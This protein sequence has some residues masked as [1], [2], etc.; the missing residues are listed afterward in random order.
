VNPAEGHILRSSILNCACVPRGIEMLGGA[1]PMKMVV[2][3][4]VAA[5]M[6][7]CHHVV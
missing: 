5:M 1:E 4:V 2:A 6:V 3:M 7:M